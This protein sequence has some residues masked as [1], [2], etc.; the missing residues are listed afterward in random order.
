MSG[1]RIDLDICII[2]SADGALSARTVAFRLA[3]R[4]DFIDIVVDMCMITRI[5]AGS[6]GICIYS[7][8]RQGQDL[9]IKIFP[10]IIFLVFTIDVG[11]VI[12]LCKNITVIDISLTI[13]F[14]C[15]RITGTDQEK[16]VSVI[17]GADHSGVTVGDIDQIAPAV[18][19]VNNI[20]HVSA[21]A[22][23]S[24]YRNT[25]SEDIVPLRQITEILEGLGVA[26]ADYGCAGILVKNPDQLPGITVISGVVAGSIVIVAGQGTDLRPVAIHFFIIRA[27]GILFDDGVCLVVSSRDSG[28]DLS[29]CLIGVQIS[30]RGIFRRDR[31]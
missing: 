3:G 2:L 10:C 22:Q 21:A 24:D 25:F 20:P 26:L 14:C 29:I 9:V 28:S 16:I 7:S 18:P 27:A 11:E 13:H 1:C 6:S 17:V 12:Q 19:E 31:E 8:F 15:I 30:A 23:I 5:F 4:G